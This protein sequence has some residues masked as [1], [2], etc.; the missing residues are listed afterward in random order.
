M[1][2]RN[3]SIKQKLIGLMILS[4]LLMAQ[5]TNLR[6]RNLNN[7]RM[8][9]Q[10]T[11]VD[12]GTKVV[13]C[14]ANLPSTGGVADASSFEGSNTIATTITLSKSTRLL[15][16]P[17]STWNFTGT[18][19]IFS[20]T[21]DSSILDCQGATIQTSG[22]AT[23]G[24]VLAGNFSGITRCNIVGPGANAA[25]AGFIGVD[26]GNKTGQFITHSH[27]S[28]W[29]SHCVNTGGSNTNF[30]FEYNF[31]EDC[32]QGGIL[33]GSGSNG[34]KVNFNKFKDI[35]SWSIDFGDSNNTEAI[36]NEIENSGDNY[37]SVNDGGGII[38]FA[39]STDVQRFNI[40]KNTIDDS[41]GF[42]ISIKAGP[43][44]ILKW[45]NVEGN[46]LRNTK[47]LV[48]DGSGAG[49]GTMTEGIISNNVIVSTP[50][51][52]AALLFNQSASTISKIMIRN[53]FVTGTTA[54]AGGLVGRG[55]WIEGA[56]IW[57]HFNT[58]LSNAAA[59]LYNGT[60]SSTAF[61]NIKNTTDA[62]CEFQDGAFGSM[63]FTG[64]GNTEIKLTSSGTGRGPFGFYIDQNGKFNC[65]NYTTAVNCMEIDASDN[66]TIPNGNFAVSGGFTQL[67]SGGLVVGSPTGGN[68]GAGSVNSQSGYATNGTSGQSGTI[69]VR[70]GDDSGACNLVFS[71]GILTSTTC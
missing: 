67:T 18:G 21:A 39:G 66:I 6:V 33:A 4:G 46:I 16:S 36:G 17:S 20:L 3:L 31:I 10:F 71:G 13:A 59:D 54:G 38:I 5:T 63:T 48:V 49:G 60:G 37:C 1:H 43:S 51:V 32:Y 22:T 9:D 24:V 52:E 28:G 7:R 29:D 30:T 50:A 27:I 55:I 12:A 42:G 41:C 58:S 68:L 53:N 14:L 40:S 62:L 69:S 61:C 56:N 64:T 19:A 45:F 65:Y 57:A 11:G 23:D 70:K 2:F 35:G 26:A 47:G 34:A 25:H 15:L 44:N 8:C